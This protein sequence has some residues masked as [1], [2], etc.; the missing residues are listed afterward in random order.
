MV[1]VVDVT[2]LLVYELKVPFVSGEFRYP[3]GALAGEKIDVIISTD[4][5]KVAFRE[6]MSSGGNITPTGMGRRRT[7]SQATNTSSGDSG[8]PNI[9]EKFEANYTILL[10]K[11]NK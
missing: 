6:G 11:G 4:P 2:D 5:S 3:I 1:N 10:T 7:S 8:T 9:T